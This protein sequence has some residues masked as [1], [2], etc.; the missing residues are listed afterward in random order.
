VF[1]KAFHS[2]IVIAF[3][4]FSIYLMYCALTGRRDA[5]IVWALVG[6]AAEAVIYL[7]F[8]RKCPL[9]LLARYLGDDGGHDYLFEW[10]LG[11]KRIFYVSR[12]LAALAVIGVLML[13]VAEIVRLA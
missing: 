6:I 7:G 11:T 2:L 13:I 4:G 9:T 1:A 5:L 12:T 3:A 8:R 10:L